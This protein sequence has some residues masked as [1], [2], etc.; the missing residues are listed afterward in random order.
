MVLSLLVSVS[1]PD[2]PGFKRKL[3]FLWSLCGAL[4]SLS[5]SPAGVWRGCWLGL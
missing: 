4:S 2:T 3:S 5:G 1:V